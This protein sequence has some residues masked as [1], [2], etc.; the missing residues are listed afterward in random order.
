[1]LKGH[2]SVLKLSQEREPR[3]ASVANDRKYLSDLLPHCAYVCYICLCV[4][5]LIFTLCRILVT[6]DSQDKNEYTR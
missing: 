5:K 3:P 1:M 4:S 6:Y 2:I